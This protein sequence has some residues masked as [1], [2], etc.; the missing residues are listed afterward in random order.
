MINRVTLEP[1]HLYSRQARS[2]VREED[3]YQEEITPA[4]REANIRDGIKRY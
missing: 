4:T 3:F 1:I 2:E